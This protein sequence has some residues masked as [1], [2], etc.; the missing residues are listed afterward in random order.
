MET[1]YHQLN[2]E[3]FENHFLNTVRN[4]IIDDTFSD[5]TLVSH[6]NKQFKAHKVI[7]T[8]CSSFFK[9]ILQSTSP[10][11]GQPVLIVLDM[12]ASHLEA[13]IEF[14]YLGKTNVLENNKEQLFK[15]AK[16]LDIF[17]L[18][19]E[20]PSIIPPAEDTSMVSQNRMEQILKNEDVLEES[21]VKSEIS[22]NE[23]V[24]SCEICPYT[25]PK[26]SKV[27]KHVLNVHG[28]AKFKCELCEYKTTRRENLKVHQ[29]SGK[30]RDDGFYCNECDFKAKSENEL[31]KHT[32]SHKYACH[33]CSYKGT[34]KSLLKQHV[35]GQH[36]GIR[37]KCRFCEYSGKTSSYLK[38]HEQSMHG[39]VSYS[40][41]ICSFDSKHPSAYKRHL[42]IM[43]SSIIS[44]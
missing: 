3:G 43:H 22:T 14:I 40:C 33:E 11:P 41:S 38:I 37:Y 36:L 6:D 30:H 39:N 20:S 32:K 18:C 21:I 44:K 42:L 19:E 5:V 25:A 26:L 2:W 29:L 34:R 7:L 16:D 8:S 27:H 13:L 35:E 23:K 28:E 1:T 9:N 15:V 24:F 12:D 17:G 10:Y 4:L 31:E